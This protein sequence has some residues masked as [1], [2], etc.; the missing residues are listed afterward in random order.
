MV[1]RKAIL[2]DVVVGLEIVIDPNEPPAPLAPVDPAVVAY[3]YECLVESS[4]KLSE[5]LQR[6]FPIK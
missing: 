2:G 5:S 1:N 4:R 6:D 3:F